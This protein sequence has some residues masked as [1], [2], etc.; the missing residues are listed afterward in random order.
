MANEDQD[1]ELDVNDDKN[2]G[3]TSGGLGKGKLLIIIGI[4]LVISLAVAAYFLFFGDDKKTEDTK[5]EVEVVEKKEPPEYIG[6]PQPITANLPGA[7]KNRTV[8][9]KM[10]FM[11]RGSDS[12]AEVKKHMPRLKNDVLMLVSQQ[13]AD[14]LQTPEGRVELQAK[15]LETVQQTLTELVGKPLVEKVLFVNFV[16]Q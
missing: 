9:I 3:K 16:M 15:A 8:Q 1:L 2:E 6:F 5:E 11:V 7:S 4:V 13:T 12:V 10:T 14:I